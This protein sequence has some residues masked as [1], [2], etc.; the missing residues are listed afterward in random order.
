M[1]AIIKI[2]PQQPKKM[3]KSL[4]FKLANLAKFENAPTATGKMKKWLSSK[5]AKMAKFPICQKDLPKLSSAQTIYLCSKMDVHCV[6]M[7][8]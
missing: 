4:S 8:H 6:Q 5:L 3:E 1:L 2:H 7:L